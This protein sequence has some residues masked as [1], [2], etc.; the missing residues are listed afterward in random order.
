MGKNISCQAI[1]PK[2]AF[3]SSGVNAH[4]KITPTTF[5]KGGGGYRIAWSLTL[6]AG[7]NSPTNVHLL[8]LQGRVK[9]AISRNLT[10][11]GGAKVGEF[12]HKMSS[13]SVGG[14]AHTQECSTPS[15]C[16][17]RYIVFIRTGE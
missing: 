17:E 2:E 7:A 15:D 6:T 11:T 4:G 3:A 16:L 14:Y 12:A 9:S 10:L 5:F 8:T 1:Y 13:S